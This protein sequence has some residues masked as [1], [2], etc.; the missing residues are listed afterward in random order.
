MKRI[1]VSGP[2][3]SIPELNFPAFHAAAAM[4]RAKGHEVVNPAELNPDPNASWADCMRVDI[5]ALVTC[6]H[7]A[8]LPNWE[9]SRG[10]KL[11]LHIATELGM[12]PIFITEGN[13]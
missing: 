7:I 6:T 11:E 2:M 1:Y 5:A 3:T 9:K 12:Q 8:L 13:L 4:L 10:A